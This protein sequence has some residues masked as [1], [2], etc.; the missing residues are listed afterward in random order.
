MNT[1]LIS[2]GLESYKPP[3]AKQVIHRERLKESNEKKADA[4]LTK[5]RGI[6]KSYVMSTRDIAYFMR[7]ER[8]SAAAYLNKQ[9]RLGHV[10]KAGETVH[11]GDNSKQFLWRLK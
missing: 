6:L 1:M 3:S 9:Q 7:V 10:E 5:L 8:A 4:T 11:A 2:L